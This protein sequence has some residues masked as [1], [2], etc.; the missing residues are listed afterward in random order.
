[1]YRSS[2]SFNNSRNSFDVIFYFTLTDFS[3][4]LLDI[5]LMNCE[6][7]LFFFFFKELSNRRTRAFIRKALFGTLWIQL[8]KEQLW[9]IQ[10]RINWK[11]AKWEKHLWQVFPYLWRYNLISMQDYGLFDMPF[12]IILQLAQYNWGYYQ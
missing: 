11:K 12:F 2:V 4:N 8:F 10:T 5:F 7:I 6:V 3:S 1:M 9:I